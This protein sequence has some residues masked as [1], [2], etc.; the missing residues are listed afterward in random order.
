MGD[1]ALSASRFLAQR[2]M[3]VSGSTGFCT[4]SPQRCPLSQVA[5]IGGSVLSLQSRLAALGALVGG[6]LF[7]AGVKAQIE[8]L[9]FPQWLEQVFKNKQFDLTI[10]S[11]TEP[12]DINIYADPNYYFQYGKPEFKT[13]IDLTVSAGTA[14]QLVLTTSAAGAASGAA[15]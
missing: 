2:W 9:Q 13:L 14:S 1:F 3:S 15:F 5:G 4:S 10:I 11:H 6:G 7:V 8:Q 12:L